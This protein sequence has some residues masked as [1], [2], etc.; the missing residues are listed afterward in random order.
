MRERFFSVGLKLGTWLWR[1][2]SRPPPFTPFI[3]VTH[4]SIRLE[5]LLFTGCFLAPACGEQT[6]SGWL[7]L[8]PRK[9]LNPWLDL[10]SHNW[11]LQTEWLK[12][13]NFISYH[14]VGCKVQD[15]GSSELSFW[16]EPS[17][18]LTE[19]HLLSMSFHVSPWCVCVDRGRKRERVSTL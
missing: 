13:H 6:C 14:S 12:Q 9:A 4:S 10:G 19:G 2:E 17:C 1:R 8:G 7:V 15:E 5:A 16:G 11:L 18:W 3:S